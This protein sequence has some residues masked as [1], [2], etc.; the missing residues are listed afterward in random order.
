MGAQNFKGSPAD[1]VATRINTAVAGDNTLVAA[2]AGQATRV[3]GLRLNV[4]GAVVVQVKTGSIIREVFNFAGSGGGVV[5]DLRELPYYTTAT[6]EAL[7]INLSGAAQV[8][9]VLEYFTAK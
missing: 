4:A 9:G 5:L 3:Y 1:P 7:V 2:V 6:N 8:D